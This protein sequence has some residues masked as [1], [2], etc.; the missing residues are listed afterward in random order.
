MDSRTTS[1]RARTSLPPDLRHPPGVTFRKS[2]IGWNDRH[3][4]FSNGRVLIIDYLRQADTAPSKNKIAAQELH[5][6]KG[7]KTFYR[8]SRADQAALRI[9]HLQN[10]PWATEFLMQKYDIS[11][12]GSHNR[13]DFGSWL[14]YAEPELRAGKPFP[15]A[16]VFTAQLQTRRALRCS[17]FTID[18]LKHY[19]VARHIPQ[20]S[21]SQLKMMEMNQYDEDGNPYHAV[22]IYAQR[23]SVYVQRS[24]SEATG[25]SEARNLDNSSTVLVFEK[26]VSDCIRDTL[27]TARDQLETRWVCCYLNQWSSSY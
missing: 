8:D 10:A 20:G 17:G 26:S 18:Y 1:T 2:N 6:L 16:R 15:K 9:I 5:S 21:G 11:H 22:D 19:P 27:L 4:S 25:E 23:L 7:L 14:T 3:A 13:D 24:E 12:K